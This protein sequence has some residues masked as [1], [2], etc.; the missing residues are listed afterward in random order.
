MITT[1]LDA[2]EIH[3]KGKKK[4][5]LLKNLITMHRLQKG[6]G[7]R[8]PANGAD[9]P[10]ASVKY[11]SEFFRRKIRRLRCV[12]AISSLSARR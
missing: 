10:A 12:M 1:I 8:H 9:L 7:N 5:S 11:R 3:Q 2:A 6:K 4:N